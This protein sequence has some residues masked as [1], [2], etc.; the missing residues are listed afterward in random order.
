MNNISINETKIEIENI[1]IDY[2]LNLAKSIA[3]QILNNQHCKKDYAKILAIATLI[4][5]DSLRNQYE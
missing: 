3:G 5:S 2:S 1:K 4:V